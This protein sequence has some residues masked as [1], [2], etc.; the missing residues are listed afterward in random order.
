MTDL[1]PQYDRPHG[2][3]HDGRLEL[4]GA[5]LEPLRE[6]LLALGD[7]MGWWI[8]LVDGRRALSHV[9]PGLASALRDGPD[10][11]RVREALDRA[12]ESMAA[13]SPSGERA[14]AVLIGGRRHRMRAVPASG[15][16]TWLLVET[17]VAK[18][19]RPADVEAAELLRAAHHLTPREA[20]VAGLLARGVSP[21]GIAAELGLSVHTARRHVES[22]QGK[23]GVH[24]GVQAAVALLGVLAP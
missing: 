12:A 21:R 19:G 15:D 9:S 5:L 3:L 7:L 10:A 8:A 1:A 4:S 11:D 13:P 6:A 23:L 16:L 20:E 14:G 17:L 18:D 24:S 2:R 22:I